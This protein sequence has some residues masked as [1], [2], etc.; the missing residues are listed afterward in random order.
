MR[1]YLL[2]HQAQ[3]D[4]FTQ[5]IHNILV[6]KQSCTSCDARIVPPSSRLVL[7]RTLVY[8]LQHRV[9]MDPLRDEPFVSY[10]V[11]KPDGN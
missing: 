11:S 1:P 4:H 10:Y 5:H 3:I 7:V 6:R 8:V 9:G 2:K